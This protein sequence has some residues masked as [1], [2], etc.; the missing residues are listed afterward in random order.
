MD[1]PVSYSKNSTTLL[2]S[3]GFEISADGKTI[4]VK[5]DIANIKKLNTY[6]Y[7]IDPQF[8]GNLNES[9][10]S[11]VTKYYPTTNWGNLRALVVGGRYEGGSG[12]IY[13]DMGGYWKCIFRI[14]KNI[15]RI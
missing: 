8:W 9:K 5:A 3:E 10:D 4:I 1:T 13:Q 15:S 11:M 2:K 12:Y 7:V 14:H 6:P